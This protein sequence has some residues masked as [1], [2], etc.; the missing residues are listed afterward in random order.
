VALK[1]YHRVVDVRTSFRLNSPNTT[2]ARPARHS[3]RNRINCDIL[4]GMD[5][6][7]MLA[8][9]REDGAQIETAIAARE[10]LTLDWGKPQPSSGVDERSIGAL[11]AGP[12]VQR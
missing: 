3:A 11:A 2:F 1:D 9:L 4:S 10:G 6:L 5:V 12:A 8:D 7:K